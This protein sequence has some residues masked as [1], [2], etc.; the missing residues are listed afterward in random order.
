MLAGA[1][2][3]PILLPCIPSPNFSTK[4]FILGGAAALPFVLTSFL[5]NPDIV[6]WH[7]AGSA[8]SY[9]LALPPVTAYLSLNFTGATTYTSK[10]GVKREIYTYIPVMAWIFGAGLV[11]TIALTIIRV[12]G[13]A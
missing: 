2:L 5:S 13:G 10:S 8:L 12:F 9:L 11:L 7:R 1:V 4:G 3:F 6:L